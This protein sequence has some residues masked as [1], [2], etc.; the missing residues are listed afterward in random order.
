MPSEK[1][2]RRP[3]RSREQ[4]PARPET[5]DLIYGRRPVT[6]FLE[7]SRRRAHRLWLDRRLDHPVTDKFTRMAR[8]RNLPVASVDP[9]QLDRMTGHGVHQGVVLEAESLRLRSLPEL[10][11]LVGGASSRGRCAFLALDGVTDPQNFGAICRSAENF[12]FSG[13]LFEVQ[14][15]PPLGGAAYKASAGSMEHLPLYG[16][17]A[18]ADALTAARSKGADI[19]GLDSHA[20]DRITPA[21]LVDGKSATLFVL[22]SEGRGMSAHVSRVCE[23]TMS[24]ASQGHVGSLNVSA[25]AA[26]VCYAWH[27]ASGSSTQATKD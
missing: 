15:S 20:P 1:H 5:T 3:G 2:K 18:L 19:I 13:I 6:L 26:V 12:G 27:E 24:I 7:K 10:V 23:R 14:S 9:G 21:I 8:G 22:G 11:A 4:A 16:V 25:A 17:S